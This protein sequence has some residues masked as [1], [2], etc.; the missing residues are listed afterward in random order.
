MYEEFFFLLG[1]ILFAR[2][3]AN[4]TKKFEFHTR[5]VIWPRD[6]LSRRRWYNLTITFA[7]HFLSPRY[8]D[9]LRALVLHQSSLLNETFH[10][11]G[12]IEN[13][14]EE[15]PQYWPVKVQC[16]NA[17]SIR[18]REALILE[19]TQ[20]FTISLLFIP[21]KFF[22]GNLDISV[23]NYRKYR[24][25]LYYKFDFLIS[26]IFERFPFYFYMLTYFLHRSSDIYY[27]L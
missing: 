8:I 15:R 17:L 27:K 21:C 4:A 22:R 2:T 13:L 10:S 23:T 18:P 3:A 5:H 14:C 1:A 25:F 7:W 26:S 6:S 24:R 9:I 11:C 19:I 12:S 16:W 20:T